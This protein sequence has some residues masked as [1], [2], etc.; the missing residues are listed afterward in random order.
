MT[1]IDLMLDNDNELRFK[2]NIESTRPG[3]SSCRLMLES[4]DVEYGFRGTTTSD[5][6]VAVTIPPL[7]NILKEGIYDTRLE[8]IVDDKI[9]TPL[10]MKINFE[11]SVVVTA[12]AIVRPRVSKPKATAVLLEA[13]SSD[14]RTP[15]KRVNQK[16]AQQEQ[17]QTLD[18]S[19]ILELLKHI[20]S[21]K[22]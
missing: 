3:D 16:P 15:I 1:P 5:G 2:V 13:S 18:A 8:V 11:K 19:Q 7:K 17:T 6:E 20:K 12:E 4:H 9:F 10:E 21:S 22:R 14:R